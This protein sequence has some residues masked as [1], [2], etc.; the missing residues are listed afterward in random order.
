MPDADRIYISRKEGGHGLIQIGYTYKASTIG[1]EKY[2]IETN[3]KLLKQ[4]YQHERYRILYS[5]EKEAERYKGG[6]Q[7]EDAETEE[8]LSVVKS[9]KQ[10]KEYAKKR[11][12]ET[13][14]EV[15][16]KKTMHWFI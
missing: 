4:V 3:E 9:A 1:L 10:A 6:I 5:I 8:N 14:K 13:I 2:L 11:I 16:E 12:M 7:V 15:W